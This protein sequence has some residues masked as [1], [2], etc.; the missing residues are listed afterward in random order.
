MS[1]PPHPNMS[2]CLQLVRSGQMSAAQAAKAY[3]VA[4]S[5][6]SRALRAAVCPCCKRNL[7]QNKTAD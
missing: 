4:K 5:S 2:I 3:G 1:R 6:I 7:P